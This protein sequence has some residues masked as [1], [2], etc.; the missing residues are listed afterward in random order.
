MKQHNIIV[1]GFARLRFR[2]RQDG[3]HSG[4]QAVG[5]NLT[6][7]AAPGGMKSLQVASAAFIFVPTSHLVQKEVCV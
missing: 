2:F 3:A 4:E 7:F 5:C 6:V 1:W